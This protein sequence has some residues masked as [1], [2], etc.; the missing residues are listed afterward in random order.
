M[1]FQFKINVP[2]EGE[3]STE[4]GKRRLSDDHG[5]INK[6]NDLIFQK[7]S[8][9]TLSVS[10]IE[11]E[12]GVSRPILLSIFKKEKGATVVEFI[13]KE[14]LKKARGLLESSSYNISEIAYQVGYSDPKYFS[15]SFRKEYSTTPTQ[16]RNRYLKMN[17]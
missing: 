1:I 16:Y 11:K 6:V 17:K 9:P 3:K 2:K 13:K 10:E 5:L 7:L 15:K 12:I 14:R 4:Q 8:D